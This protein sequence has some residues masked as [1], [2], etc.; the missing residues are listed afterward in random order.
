MRRRPVS[1]PNVTLETTALSL[2]AACIVA[3]CVA[4]APGAGTRGGAGEAA[5]VA[6]LE[7]HYFRGM[8]A[9]SFEVFAPAFHPEARLSFVADG[10]LVR[11]DLDEW[12]ARLDA[13]RADA[14]HP[15]LHEV[16]EKR[17]EEVAV[18]GDV[19]TATV[20]FVFP[21]RVYTDFLQLVRVR[22]E[23]KILAK[24]FDLELTP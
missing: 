22:D 5:I 24:S 19:A 4:H 8:D 15:L 9:L 11:L 6:M 1:S 23:W 13:L 12:R 3:G 20:R 2:A 17:I 7:R 18:V 10:A 21:S 16:S 14:D